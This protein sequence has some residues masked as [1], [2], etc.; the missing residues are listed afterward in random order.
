MSMANLETLELTINANAESASRGLS[1]LINS[2]SNLT[3][4]ITEAF[5]SLS[6]LNNELRRL[7]GLG[8]TVKVPGAAATTG[9]RRT[10]S[11]NPKGIRM[12]VYQPPAGGLPPNAQVIDPAT[13]QTLKIGTPEDLANLKNTLKDAGEGAEKSESKFSKFRAG[14]KTLGG[15]LKKSIMRFTGLN[16]VLRIASTMLIRMGVKALFN[17]AKE[18]FKNFVAYARA[19]GNEMYSQIDGISS[20]WG[21]IKNQ[22]GASLATAF[23]AAIPVI[24]SLANAAMTAFNHL[25]QLIA[26]LTGKTSWTAA[27]EVSG[28]LDDVGS[29]AGGASQKIKELLADFDELNVIA[30]ESGGGGGGG[31]TSAQDAENMFEEITQFDEKIRALANFLKDNFESIKGIAIAI[32]VAILA[33]KLAD[34]FAETL[35][36]LSKLAGLVG[37]GAVIAITLQATWVLTNEYLSSGDIGWLIADMFTSA[38]GA[39]AAWAIAKHFIGGN[40][41]AWAASITLAFSALTGIKAVVDDADVS[42]LSKKSIVTLTENALKA[43]AAA[44]ILLKTVGNSTWLVAAQGAAGIALVVFGAAVGIKAICDN[45]IEVFSKESV[46][47]GI[48]SAAS[49][50]LGLAVLGAGWAIAAGAAIATFFAY[51]GIKALTSKNKIEVSDGLVTLTQEEVQTFVTTHMFSINPDIMI[52]VTADTISE[53]DMK[54]EEIETKIGELMGT[55]E[56]LRLGLATD[57]DYEGLKEQITGKDGLISAVNGWIDEAV[58]AGQLVLKFTPKIAGETEEEQKEWYTQFSQGWETVK[59]FMN[60]LGEELGKEIT[61]GIDG[62]IVINNP[63]RVTE[64]INQINEL[65][66]IIAGTD[67]STEAEINLDL[68][69]S[70]LDSD[71]FTE[72]MKVYSDYKT[73]MQAAAEEI[74]KTALANQTRL[75]N[76]L[77]KMLEIDPNNA[78]LQKQLADAETA[79]EELKDDLKQKTDDAFADLTTPGKSKLQEWVEKNFELGSVN[80]RWTKEYIEDF[81]NF[82]G[83]E[84]TL[85]EVFSENGFDMNVIDIRDLIE[86]GGWDLLSADL[87]NKLVTSLVNS[88]GASD[89]I[90]QFKSLGI[91]ITGWI[92][93][94]LKSDNQDVKNAAQALQAQL[95]SE[96]KPEIDVTADMPESEAKNLAD[97]VKNKTKPTIDVTADISDTEGKNLANKVKDKT[98]NPAIDVT[99]NMTSTEGKNLASRVQTQTG[100]PT[101]YAVGSMTSTAGKNLKSTIVTQTGNPTIYALGTMTSSAGKSLKSTI[102][103][104][105]GN[106][107]IY[108]I[109][110]MTKKKGKALKKDIVAKTGTPEIGTD[111]Y[112]SKSEKADLKSDIE[113]IDPEVSVKAELGNTTSFIDKIKEALKTAWDAILNLFGL[114]GKSSKG[115]T[116]AN[117]FATGGFPT[118]GSVF[119]AGE[120]GPEMVGMINGRSAVSNNDQI[121]EGISNGVYRANSEQNALLRQQ[122]DLLR[123]ILA[124][125]GSGITPSAALGR[126]AKQSIDMYGSMTG[127]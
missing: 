48:I 95:E 69:L 57:N 8:N 64:I 45:N 53:L 44:G 50:G 56:I 14:M 5:N 110:S 61:T 72:V 90:A 24:N 17:G 16:R 125:S 13:G 82:T 42:A 109:G 119:I 26:L 92:A 18:G 49:V 114:G 79:L 40:A 9:A 117:V 20:K 120:A 51:I 65:A 94:G 116:K 60:Q 96:V 27:T 76:A 115:G 77:K 1:T 54:K 70:D 15:E 25:S 78:D 106:P 121:V 80:V 86:V 105:T 59:G 73:Q 63:E 85:S 62:K 58:Q 66:S 21:Q 87:K 112:A 46:V 111:P 23:S 107:T 118:R 100:N 88:V 108:A 31:G 103:T 36:L 126:I 33:W 55:L 47:S 32:G 84:D 123:A 101:I 2:L 83:F 22:L 6:Q 124:K 43:G 122:N 19:T 35:P 52:K 4:K 113:G 10:S 127:G 75:V 91:D 11:R 99:G 29:S 34:T 89:A 104:Q 28:T 3:T 7:N 93:D 38:V 41:G 97:K 74:T 98:G 39:T 81:I 12:P 30:S 67:I 37:V 71:S 68:K 102:V